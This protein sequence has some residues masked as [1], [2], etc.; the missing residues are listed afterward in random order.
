MKTS[1]MKNLKE[2]IYLST[3]IKSISD[4]FPINKVSSIVNL[5]NLSGQLL[6]EDEKCK[7]VDIQ[8]RVDQYAY[9]VNNL[10]KCQK[11]SILMTPIAINIKKTEREW[12]ADNSLRLSLNP[13]QLDKTCFP[14][15]VENCSN[16]LTRNVQGLMDDL[17]KTNPSNM[18]LAA[19]LLLNLLFKYAN[20]IPSPYSSF[21][22]ISLYDHCKVS[23]A[24]AVCLYEFNTANEKGQKEP[25]LL[26]GGDFSGI[27]SYIYQIV[28]KYAGK[29]LKGR[30]F[31]LRILSDAIVR[32]IL[33]KLQLYQTNILYNSGGSFY[34][35]APNT[36]RIIDELQNSIITI[37]EHLFK[38]HRTTLFVAVDYVPLAIDAL[39]H[40][41]GKSLQD[42]WGA[43]FQKRDLKKSSKFSELLVN[44]FEDFFC[45][46]N[47]GGDARIDTISGEE[48]Q[49]GELF[50]DKNEIGVLRDIT[51]RQILLGKGLRDADVLV[52]SEE[53]IES[54][55]KG[56]W[57]E[58]A[59][60]GFYYYLVKNNMIE[61]VRQ[62]LDSLH[63]KVWLIT[64]N[65]KGRNC[66]FIPQCPTDNIYS[67]EFYGGNVFNN[68]TFSE[69]C[70]KSSNE[71][72][73]ERLGVLRMDVDNLGSLFQG[74][75]CPQKAVLARYAS[76]SRSFDYFFSGYLNVIQQEL[77]S[78]TSFIIYSGGDDVFIVGSWDDMIKI[79][80]RI[81][82]DFREFTCRNSAFSISGGIAIIPP[83]YP[84]I[85]GAEE[86][87]EEEERAKGH[88]CHGASKNSIS[89][90]NMALN[91]DLEYPAVKK[92]KD[93][94]IELYDKN[95]LPKSF[96][97]KIIMHFINANI[98]NH[99][100]K[101]LKIYWLL[102]YDLSR[103]VNRQT[104]SAVKLLLEN[105]KSE[106]CGMNCIRLNGE[107][108]C[109][110]YHPLELWAFAARWAELDIRT[111]KK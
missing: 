69:F 27:Q 96:I 42:V 54:W 59:S 57:V 24:L 81:R 18:K 93:K 88:V 21:S 44:K 92:L 41:D 47:L 98:Q 107:K 15:S 62:T 23:A 11:R 106:I 64:L 82:S 83:K 38:V 87:A 9:G 66:V 91:W 75:I 14:K 30:S 2:Y 105:C 36:S 32:F 89:F 29:N 48:I 67:L 63:D 31:Y 90:M 100:I 68:Q 102:A 103:M 110:E 71:D 10:Q 28:S 3:L 40:Q 51:Y 60:L 43:L 77:A 95:E 52:V 99:Q 76:F 101:S 78:S 26:I 13:L 70:E 108:I 94:I 74:G 86:S 34:I 111:N 25:F 80:E 97:S 22:D 58:P 104:S 35:I 7:I 65:G 61:S 45:P 1:N 12:G 56:N 6:T 109:T 4:I 72:A 5:L 55:L 37:E 20:S 79:A 84:L 16:E 8:E 33:K 49:K 19:E 46:G 85:K 50:N 53:P 39:M 17:K 73:Y